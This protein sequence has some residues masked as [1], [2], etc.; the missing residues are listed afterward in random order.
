MIA[1]LKANADELA[2]LFAELHERERKRLLVLLF[3]S[4]ASLWLQRLI[5]VNPV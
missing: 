1:D 5:V 2:K 4:E 3:G